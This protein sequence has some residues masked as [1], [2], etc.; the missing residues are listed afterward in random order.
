MVNVS[1]SRIDEPAPAEVYDDALRWVIPSDS[2]P[3]VSYV[4]ELN[5]PPGYSVC[6]CKWF[7]C[8]LGPLLRRG[9]SPETAVAEG[10]VKLK[11]A[12]RVED[13]LKCKH[14]RDA[15]KRLALAAIKSLAKARTITRHASTSNTTQEY[16]E[17]QTF[18][19]P[20][21]FQTSRG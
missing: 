19:P 8:T 21:R 5:A 13:V 18:T 12:D 11:K 10:M 14:I 2:D 17:P 3:N 7:E 4:V 20:P 1:S 16:R 15:E 9:V 6:T